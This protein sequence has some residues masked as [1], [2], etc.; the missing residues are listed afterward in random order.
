MRSAH[1]LMGSV[2]LGIRVLVGEVVMFYPLAEFLRAQGWQDCRVLQTRTLGCLVLLVFRPH[3]SYP[4]VVAKISHS[5]EMKDFA[6]LEA[7]ALAQLVSVSER[8]GA[9]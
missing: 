4:A 1:G 3:Q 2:G 6:R 7:A 8:V 9:P 5:G